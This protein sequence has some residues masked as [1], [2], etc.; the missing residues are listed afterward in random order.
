MADGHGHVITALNTHLGK[1]VR[2]ERAGAWMPGPCLS[3]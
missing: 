2:I 3:N 1:D